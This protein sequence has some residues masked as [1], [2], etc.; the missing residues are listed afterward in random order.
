VL[1]QSGAR[2][3]DHPLAFASRKLSTTDINY[4]T[5][6]REELDMVYAL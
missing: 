5:T 6:K 2:D 3:I 1:A 4:T